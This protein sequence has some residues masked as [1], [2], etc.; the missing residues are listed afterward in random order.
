MLK[1]RRTQH[2][3]ICI[4]EEKFLVRPGGRDQVKIEE[5]DNCFGAYGWSD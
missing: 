3:D 5:T 4:Y 2:H 1:L